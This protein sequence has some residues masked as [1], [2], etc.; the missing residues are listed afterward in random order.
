M[1]K[2]GD[3]RKKMEM[4]SKSA[5]APNDRSG[6]ENGKVEEYGDINKSTHTQDSTTK[7]TRIS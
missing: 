7:H 1:L 3:L 4:P 6:K 5:Y 2:K